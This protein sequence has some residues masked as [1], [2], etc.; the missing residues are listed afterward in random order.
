MHF[1]KTNSHNIYFYNDYIIKSIKNKKNSDKLL[2]E[3]NI[4][5]MI[6]IIIKKYNLDI[7]IPNIYEKNNK[8]TYLKMEKII[9]PINKIKNNY[10][11]FLEIPIFT[12]YYNNKQC[13]SMELYNFQEIY[14]FYDI[15]DNK[16]ILINYKIPYD[17]GVIFSELLLNNNIILSDFELIAGI[18]N[19][20]LIDFDKIHY[21]NK[22]TKKSNYNYDLK[23]Y[24][25]YYPFNNNYNIQKESFING[26]KFIDK[27]NYIINLL[28]L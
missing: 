17:L 19:I 25:N 16:T 10:G 24:M 5:K 18:N 27:K 7:K 8:N 15:H 3:Y 4:N 21:F 9:F 14:K 28:E 26:I 20:Y 1:I 12:Y 2:M 11:I 6:E 22:N 23:D 13:N